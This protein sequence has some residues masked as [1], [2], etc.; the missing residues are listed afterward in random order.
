M[1]DGQHIFKGIYIAD[2]NISVHY[3]T[4]TEQNGPNIKTE[5]MK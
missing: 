5:A 1:H 2:S 3:I 4:L